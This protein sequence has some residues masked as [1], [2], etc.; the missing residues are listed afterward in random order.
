M[1][2]TDIARSPS[3]L[4]GIDVET[5]TPRNVV[6]AF[7][8]SITEGACAT[9]GWSMSWPQQLSVRLA[10]AR[11]GKTWTI[12][13]AG[14]SGNR[15]LYDGAGMKALDRF[16]R[17]VLSIPGLK[18]IVLLEGIN[19]IGNAFVPTSDTGPRTAADVIGAYTQLIERAHARNIRIYG[20]TLLPYAG[21]S[22]FTPQGEAV[23]TAV[24]TWIRTSGAF[25]GIVDFDAATR[26][27]AAP[28][29]L[30]G[31][32]QCGDNLHPNDA[33]YTA[34]ANAVDLNLIT[35]A[36]KSPRR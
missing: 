31:A 8:D 23:R 34:M 12:I 35:G 18:S 21:A 15:L 10:K 13:N 30:I 24:N 6:V 14:I 2:F 33:G 3:I 20:G 19:D 32:Y 28:D 26:D 16:N 11:Q 22:Y 17:D 36:A 4:S 5:T 29:H 1:P 27:S 7:G 9:P 25:D